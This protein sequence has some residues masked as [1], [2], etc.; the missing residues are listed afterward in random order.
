MEFISRL[1]FTEDIAL[2]YVIG[3]IDG[4]YYSMQNAPI[5]RES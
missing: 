3:V 1:R 4:I 5:K 2:L